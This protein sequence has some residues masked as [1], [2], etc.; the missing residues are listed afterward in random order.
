MKAD[1]VRSQPSFPLWIDVCCGA[2][3]T[4]KL[5]YDQARFDEASMTRTLGHYQT[6][7]HGLTA[8]TL[9][10]LAPGRVALGLG[11]S[12]PV[13]VEQWNGVPFRN[14]LLCHRRGRPADHHHGR[15]QRDQPVHH[16]YPHSARIPSARAG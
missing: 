11:L 4:L 13:V 3:V 8:A 14:R 5:G 15:H 2:E 7:L 9:G 12:S 6:V 10:R 1:S 16:S